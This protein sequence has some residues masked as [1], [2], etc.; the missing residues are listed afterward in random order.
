MNEDIQNKLEETNRILQEEKLNRFLIKQ[1]RMDER[2]NIK[3]LRISNS[4]LFRFRYE[5][6]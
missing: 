3:N 6:L 5:E 1:R 2:S 4:F